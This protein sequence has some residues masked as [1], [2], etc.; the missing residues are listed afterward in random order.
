MTKGIFRLF[1][2]RL[3]LGNGVAALAGL[4]LA[5]LPLQG[6]VASGLFIGVALL[7]AAGSAFN[8]VLERDIDRLMTRTRLRPIPSGEM[9]HGMAVLIAT[10]AA[11]AGLLLLLFYCGM[12]VTIIGAA[13][14]AWYLG[15]YT[16]LKRHTPLALLAGAFCGAIPPLMGWL[17]AAGDPADFRVVILAGLFYLWQVPHFWLLQMRHSEDY[18]AAGLP[19]VR[20]AGGMTGNLCTLWISALIAAALLLPL[21]GVIAPHLALWYIIPMV[22]LCLT[23]LLR[24]KRP[25]MPLLNLFPIFLAAFF[26]IQR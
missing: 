2:L 25:L 15:V 8:Q 9:T 21:F 10:L 5:P 3:A 23:T 1:R 4:F 13:A 18:Q 20:F 7:A 19:V 24:K 17:S 12:V 16:P 6:A 26:L 11:L 22:I 14:M